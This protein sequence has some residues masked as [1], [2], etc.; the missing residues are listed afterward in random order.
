V[1]NTTHNFAV[2][3]Q[4]FNTARAFAGRCLGIVFVIL[5]FSS[6]ASAAPSPRF[7]PGRI[8]V[9]P[10]AALS[11]TNLIAKLK[12]HGATNHVLLPQSGVHVVAVSEDQADATIA[13][14][15][16]DPEIEFA[17][18][19]YI[20]QTAFVPNDPYVVSGAE[21]QLARI[22]ADQAWD[23]TAGST[24]V[25]VAVLDSGINAAVPDLAGQV[26]PGYD[27]VS[28][29]ADP[30]DDFGHGTAVAGVIAATGNNGIGVAGVAFGCRLLPV[31]VVDSSGYATY[32][33]IVQGIHYAVDHGARIINLS[34]AGDASSSALQDAVNYA[35]G[36]NVIVVASAGN[37]GNNTPQYPA[38]CAHV[39]GV[40]A[41][42][43]NDTL[44][45]FSSYGSYITLSAPGDNIWT[46]QRTPD[47]PIGSWAGTSFSSPIV[48]AVAALVASENPSL[49][50]DQIVSILKQNADDLGGRG[51]DTSFGYGRVNAFRAVSAASSLPGALPPWTPP[52]QG[53][54]NETIDTTAP[55]LS[56]TS[57]PLNHSR[58]FAPQVTL[59][60][61]A[62][63]NVGVDKIEVRVNGA[64]QIASGTTAWIAAVSLAPGLNTIGIRGVDAA[65]NVSAEV[66]RT[67]TYVFHT[68]LK[69]ETSGIG[70]V[71]PD[72]DG[73]LLEVGKAYSIKAVPGAG[74]C[75]AGWDG[76]AAPSPV[77]NFT[78]QTNLTLVANFVPSPFPV[79]KGRFAG[80]IANTNEITPESSGCFNLNVTGM[81]AF[82]GKIRVAGKNCSFRGQFDLNGNATINVKRKTSAPLTLGM[83]VDLTNGTDQLTGQIAGGNWI[84][85]VSGDRD[86]FNAK[87]NPA[88]QAGFRSFIL[89]QSESTNLVANGRSKISAAGAT[90]VKGKLIDGR[91][92]SAGST[93]AKNG[94][95]PFYLSFRRG[96][97]V[98]I[99]WLNF[100]ATEPATSGA[101]LWVQAGTNGFAAT[102]QAAS[103]P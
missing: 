50:N 97:E 92:F 52:A 60:G 68:P 86:V 47:N 2:Q 34:V 8:L 48:A 46:T 33:T 13:S 62:A 83:H 44:A 80:L 38:A 73:K 10:K 75:F 53:S 63:D 67:Y 102:L 82:T 31:K 54:T 91:A 26:L 32:S 59:A 74:E 56:L 87:F 84:A 27:F 28:N 18:R 103:A 93:L 69:V 99:G 5:I 64:L 51:Y 39:V 11:E 58:L 90:Q 101:V 71:I 95:Y 45:S 61:T 15:R 76:Q 4:T 41:T 35:W 20:A 12:S 96:S 88:Q 3:Q 37:N 40:S 21:W 89:E 29:D 94:D 6:F 17:E 81:G 42:E 66:V 30:A 9:K 49:S 25:V 1:A 98:V 22:Q 55:T 65:G 85:E 16:K 70:K 100:P 19:D 72:L 77:L 24:D 57:A 79:V 78:M 23:I 43:P 7:V 14:L 36:S